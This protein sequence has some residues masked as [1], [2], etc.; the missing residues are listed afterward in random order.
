MFADNQID[1]VNEIRDVQPVDDSKN[2]PLQ[3]HKGQLLG[4]SFGMGGSTMIAIIFTSFTMYYLTSIVH[5]DG[6]MLGTLILIGSIIGAVTSFAT[7]I[8]IDKFSSKY[9][10]VRPWLLISILPIA[11]SL[12]LLFSIPESLAMFTKMV[13]A[14][15]CIILYN[16]GNSMFASA[17]G[18][19]IPMATRNPLE[20]TKM[21]SGRGLANMAGAMVVTLGYVPVIGLLGGDQRAYFIVT[22]VVVAIASLLI[23]NQFRTSRE[24]V[25]TVN[26]DESGIERKIPF[27]DAM[28]SILKNRYFLTACLVIFSATFMLSL[29]NAAAVYYAQ[30]VLGNINLQ[31]ALS[32]VG[33]IPTLI[34]FA[35]LPTLVKKLG[36]RWIIVVGAL[37]VI[38]GCLLRLM[39]TSS[40]PLAF[41][42]FTLS[43]MGS[44]PL[45]V[46]VTVLINSTID[47]GEWKSGI[48]SPG[49]MMSLVGM[50]TL[51]ASS[52]SISSIGWILGATH[53]DGAAAQQPESAMQGIFTI[54]TYMPMILAAV[55]FVCILF[56]RLEKKLPQIVSE[57]RARN[58]E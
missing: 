8:M 58:G 51:L 19:L 47:Y 3:L 20:V 48:R 4:D 40:V 52:L 46:L 17:S 45:S 35:V 33:I 32:L 15:A 36:A 28:L 39:N 49:L 21:G 50:A 6:I 30:Y 34:I 13:W 23:L 53:Y 2:I 26:R 9:G 54:S 57:L 1:E 31:S 7:G 37:I 29:N 27:K 11:G 24:N 43:G 25:K 12:L 22:A 14:G 41:I 16:I 18:S 56:W 42:G 44:I 38:V 10:K 55:C 5:L